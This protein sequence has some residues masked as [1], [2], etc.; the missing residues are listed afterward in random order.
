MKSVLLI[1]FLVLSTICYICF[2]LIDGTP[3]LIGIIGIAGMLISV[4][5]NT[6]NLVTIARNKI[7]KSA[8]VGISSNIVLTSGIIAQLT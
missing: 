5:L 7:T 1:G 2:L 8:P 4:F 3:A 6:K